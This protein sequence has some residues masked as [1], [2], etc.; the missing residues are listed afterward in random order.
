[1]RSREFCEAGEALRW[2]LRPC[3]K[4]CECSSGRARLS[5]LASY[6]QRAAGAAQFV[7][8]SADA[9][10]VT[11]PG[12]QCSTVIP[13]SKL[14]DSLLWLCCFTGRAAAEC[15]RHW[16]L[17]AVL[18]GR[19][20]RG[21]S[22]LHKHCRTCYSPLLYLYG[23]GVASAALQS[24]SG[25]WCTAPMLLRAKLL[26]RNGWHQ[27]TSVL[28]EYPPGTLQLTGVLG[29]AAVLYGI[30]AARKG[31]APPGEPGAL[32]AQQRCGRAAEISLLCFASI[33][34]VVASLSLCWAGALHP[35]GPP[36]QYGASHVCSLQGVILQGL[37]LPALL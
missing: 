22:F 30:Y 20:S 33:F 36:S 18:A 25:L 24:K 2:S 13:L 21:A 32:A 31:R 8:L 12:E 17:H 9:S 28:Q 34:H 37:V 6:G 35:C 27:Y 1:M 7:P 5:S 26:S 23:Y 4:F 11:L 10:V 29:L 3:G 14:P 15:K 16:C 19:S